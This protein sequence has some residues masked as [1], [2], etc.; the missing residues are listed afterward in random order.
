[1]SNDLIATYDERSDVL[2]VTT[3]PGAPAL[4]KHGLLGLVLR[5]DVGTHEPIGVTVLDFSEYWRHRPDQLIDEIA[6]HLHTPRQTTYE[7][8]HRH[9]H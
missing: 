6:A 3:R 2:Y 4:S 5:Y 8:V 7:A 9:W 1:M